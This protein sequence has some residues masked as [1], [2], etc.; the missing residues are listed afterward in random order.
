MKIEITAILKFVKLPLTETVAVYLFILY[1]FFIPY[2][3]LAVFQNLKLFMSKGLKIYNK[4]SLKA[5]KK[6]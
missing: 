6:F 2:Y 4:M 1:L 3:L 5:I